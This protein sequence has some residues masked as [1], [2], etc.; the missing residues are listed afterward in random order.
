MCGFVHQLAVRCR[1]A[2]SHM[3]R[4]VHLMRSWNRG[5]KNLKSRTKFSHSVPAGLF[6]RSILWENKPIRDQ[7]ESSQSG[8]QKKKNNT[9]FYIPTL[10]SSPVSPLN[11]LSW[12]LFEPKMLLHTT[13]SLSTVSLLSP[14]GFSS[15]TTPS[16]QENKERNITITILF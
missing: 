10:R 5:M 15:R 8:E 12:V 11:S 2:G 1:A 6:Q 16:D 7:K 3:D 9:Q 14:L 13:F 4:E